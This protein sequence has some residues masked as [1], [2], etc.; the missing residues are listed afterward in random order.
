MKLI[1]LENLNAAQKN[2]IYKRLAK[3]AKLTKGLAGHNS[4]H[5]MRVSTAQDQLKSGDSVPLIMNKKRW[6]KT[7]TVMR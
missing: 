4:G 5:S 7:D 1:S 6:S 2:R 3:E